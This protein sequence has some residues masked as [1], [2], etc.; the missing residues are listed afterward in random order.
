L[1]VVAEIK[2]GILLT[3]L[4]P[5]ARIPEGKVFLTLRTCAMVRLEMCTWE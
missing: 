4:T 5:R 2:S 3:H 1:S